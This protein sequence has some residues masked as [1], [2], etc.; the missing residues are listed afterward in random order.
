LS[1]QVQEF[2]RR[3]EDAPAGGVN[4]RLEAV[5]CSE[6]P[7]DVMFHDGMVM[8][9]SRAIP[10]RNKRMLPLLILTYATLGGTTLSLTLSLR[11]AKFS[12]GQRVNPG[13][14]HKRFDFHLFALGVARAAGGAVVQRLDA[15]PS[16]H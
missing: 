9:S 13:D 10:F 6:L 7:N 5:V 4:H 12:D 1:E 15:V 16:E 11:A 3:S 8:N 2:A 14:I